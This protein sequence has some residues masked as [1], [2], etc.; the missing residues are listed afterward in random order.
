MSDSKASITYKQI[1]D[2][3][4]AGIRFR[5]RRADIPKYL[6]RLYEQA[7]PYIA[8]PPMCL[9][10]F[11]YS[12]EDRI[13]EV[14][15]PVSQAVADGEIKSRVLKG[16][17]MISAA[18]VGPADPSEAASER[19]ELFRQFVGYLQENA[20]MTVEEAPYREIY[21]EGGAADDTERFVTE[22]QV[23]LFLPIWLERLT[24]G[25]DRLA[26]A[27]VRQAVMA[28]SAAFLDSDSPSLA[29]AEWVKGAM[30]RLDAAVEDEETRRAIMLNRLHGYPPPRIEEVRLEYERLGD[31]DKLIEVM[32]ADRSVGGERSWYEQMRRE[33]NII[34]VTKD[35]SNPEGHREAAD[36][37]EKRANYCYCP[38]IQALIRAQ[39]NISP[40]FCYCG[41]GWS[42]QL[43]ESILGQPVRVEVVR[44]VAQ[45]DEDCTVAV[46]IPPALVQA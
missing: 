12:A 4:I 25:L 1:D 20:I 42:K 23:Q 22:L 16:G 26:G 41:A 8:G 38:V 14:C 28:G 43:W 17:S 9:Y 18:H 44:S 29:R 30:E 46:H 35:P 24:E 27:E 39:A 34:Y 10:H 36:P 19:T 13:L 5:G 15:F 37:V 7:K 6:N 2:M 40:T 21:L 32:R 3:L 11:T 33:G 45:G 31:I